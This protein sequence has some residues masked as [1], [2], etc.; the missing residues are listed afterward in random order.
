[1]IFGK[2]RLGHNQTFQWKLSGVENHSGRNPSPDLE[3]R[4]GSGPGLNVQNL[5]V[6]VIAAGRAGDMAGL[7]CATGATGAELRSLPAVRTTTAL[8][9]ADGLSALR[10]GH[11]SVASFKVV[12]LV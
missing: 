6:T 3:I 9:A 11:D 1:M 5:T 4:T 10:D 7:G 2:I 12:E 8:L